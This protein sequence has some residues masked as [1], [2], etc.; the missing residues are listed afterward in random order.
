MSD[1]QLEKLNYISSNYESNNGGTNKEA[2]I[3]TE[4]IANVVSKISLFN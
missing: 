3:I 4:C 1:D 2:L